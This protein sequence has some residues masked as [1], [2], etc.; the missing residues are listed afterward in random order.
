MDTLLTRER[1]LA[2]A[3]QLPGFP[4]VIHEILA[5]LDDPDANMRVLAGYIQ[6][7]P[8]IAARVLFRANTAAARVGRTDPVRD[9]S[10][11]LS[12]IG[13]SKVREIAVMT[14]L[15]GFIDDLVEG[16]M[17]RAL[18]RH[19]VVVGVCCE[20]VAR[21][22]ATVPLGTAMIAGLLHDIGQLWLIRFLPDAF[23]EVLNEVRD[24]A[25]AIDAAERSRF[26]FD[27]ATIGAWL[28]ENWNLPGNLVA[29]I[30]HHHVPDFALGEPL[31]PVIHVAEVL[32]HALDLGE[33]RNSR[34]V[35]LCPEACA[36][37]GLEWDDDSRHLFGRIE[38]R[39][40]HAA[41]LL[42]E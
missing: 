9:V 20:E 2:S 10:F 3:D 11:A 17:A 26:G 41:A 18:W 5:T 33:S 4:R 38:G 31:V 37:L 13:Q 36:A 12:L 27:H 28:A 7:D 15:S 14:S 23:A 39:S 19:S 24:G 8:V 30:L 6:L 1:V 21:D 29:A 22:A 40:G 42:G 35:Y 25:I 16:A 32:S 34:V